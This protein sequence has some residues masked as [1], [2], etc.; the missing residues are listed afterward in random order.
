MS[1]H[2]ICHNVETRLLYCHFYELAHRRHRNQ[3]VIFRPYTVWRYVDDLI[4]IMPYSCH[5]RLCMR[6][7]GSVDL[8]QSRTIITIIV[9]IVTRG[10]PL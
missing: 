6:E 2:Q 8:D 1:P 9:E 5:L 10:Y 7:Y 3:R 4:L